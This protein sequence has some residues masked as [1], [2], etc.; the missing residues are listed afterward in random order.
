M[1]VYG[2]DVVS[3]GTTGLTSVLESWNDSVLDPAA[4][5]DG[6]PVHQ[7]VQ[8]TPSHIQTSSQARLCSAPSY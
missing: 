3:P 7:V 1:V 5:P 4:P 8:V 6:D 2:G